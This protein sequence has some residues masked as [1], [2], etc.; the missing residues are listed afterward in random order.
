MTGAGASDILAADEPAL[1]ARAGRAAGGG[2]TE[3]M[4]VVF[5]MPW[6]EGGRRHNC[7]FVLGPDGT[8][9]TRYAQLVVDRP[10]LFA[11]GRARRRCGS[12]SRACP[13]S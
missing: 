4:H 5:G 9:L 3:R 1:R 7:A 8:L 6:L 2:T 11:A 13:A 10:E 12:T